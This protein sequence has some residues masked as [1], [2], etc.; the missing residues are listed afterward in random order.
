MVQHCRHASGADEARRFIC[1]ELRLFVRKL[2]VEPRPYVPKTYTLPLRY[3]LILT[4]LRPRPT[5]LAF[6]H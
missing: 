3:I 6:A 4:F 5:K 2:G 1:T